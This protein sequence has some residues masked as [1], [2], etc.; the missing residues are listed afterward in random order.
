MKNENR[1]SGTDKFRVGIYKKLEQ[2]EEDEEE[3][4][5]TQNNDSSS[6]EIDPNQTQ[7]E[8]EVLEEIDYLDYEIEDFDNG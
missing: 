3:E 5:I 7:V 8:K 4:V 6:E 1:T 2:V